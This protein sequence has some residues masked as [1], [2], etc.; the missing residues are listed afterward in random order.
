MSNATH[1]S[2]VTGIRSKFSKLGPTWV[3][4]AIA[5]GPASMAAVLGAGAT[6]G[7]AL[8]WVVVL[9]ALLGAT[10]QYLSMRL[11]LLTERGIVG[12]VEDH[13]GELWAWVL[14]IDTVLA[15]GLAQIVIMKTVAEVSGTITGFDARLWSVVWAL[16]LA[17]GLAGGGYRFLE[18][19]AKAI[20][21]VVVVA[22]VASAFFVPIDAGAAASGMVPTIPNGLD[23]ALL[24]AGVLGGAVHITLITMQSY[25]MQA[26]GWT[27]EDYDLG[28]FDVATSML[29]AFGVFSVATFLVAASVLAPE[30][31]PGGDLNAAVAADALGPLAGE[32]AQA[33]FL[34]GLWGAAVSTLGANTVVPPYLLADKLGWETNVSDGR[35]RA[36]VVAVA[37]I[38][39]LGA[40]LGG[41][42]FTLLVVMLA[43]GL[44]GTPFALVVVLYLL[45]HPGAVPEQNP[46]A[47]NVGGVAVLVIAS[48]L[49]GV[50]VRDQYAQGSLTDPVT[51]FVLAF[52]VAMAAATLGLIGKFVLSARRSTPTVEAGSDA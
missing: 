51:A 1:D 41:E 26:R 3:A 37:L 16:V 28:R 8:L 10:T 44:V 6:F 33:L 35:F 18:V 19:G 23:G 20:V 47:A 27:R 13:L 22:F 21:S 17:A 12:A 40:F 42:F 24:A 38:G 9:S 30:F 32:Y 11:G 25:T 50:F 39:A 5:A 15:S 29:V 46:T 49:A 14:V 2:A 48:V 7:Y 36:A 43:F 31:S 45:N 4:G 52:A 34:F